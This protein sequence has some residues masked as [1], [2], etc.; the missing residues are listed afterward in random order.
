MATVVVTGAG[1]GIGR[2]LI[3]GYHARGDPPRHKQPEM[4]QFAPNSCRCPFLGEVYTTLPAGR[5]LHTS[6][7]P[8]LSV[9]SIPQSAPFGR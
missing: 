1:R 9:P 8:W 3:N 5:S 6:R 7:D 2:A 4:V